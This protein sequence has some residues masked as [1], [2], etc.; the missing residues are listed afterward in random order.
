MGVAAE[1]KLGKAPP[2]HQR[3]ASR[4]SLVPAHLTVALVF[5]Y[6][7]KEFYNATLQ[8][9]PCGTTTAS[10]PGSSLG[11]PFQATSPTARR[12]RLHGVNQSP[13]SPP[14]RALPSVNISIS[15]LPSSTR[16]FGAFMGPSPMSHS[17][18]LLRS[19]DWLAAF[20]HLTVHR[21]KP[22]LV[23]SAPA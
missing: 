1:T 17:L 14:P 9:Q 5:W 7:K 8:T 19:G 15:I 21:D 2:G 11:A 20:G 4:R 16:L 18:T 22:R 12:S 13:R 10:R 23:R 6:V 3:T